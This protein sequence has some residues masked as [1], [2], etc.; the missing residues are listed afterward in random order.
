VIGESD[1]SLTTSSQGAKLGQL[2]HALKAVSL[3]GQSL[4]MKAKNGA[5]IGCELKPDVPRPSMGPPPE[6]IPR[7]LAI[8]LSLVAGGW[9][10]CTAYSTGSLQSTPND[11]RPNV[12]AGR[13]LYE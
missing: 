5:V 7:C 8:D 10:A 6:R 4:S 2:E 1:F 13:S 3:G 11:P 12:I 9:I